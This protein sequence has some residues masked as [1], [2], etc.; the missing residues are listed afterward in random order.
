[1]DPSDRISITFGSTTTELSVIFDVHPL[2]KIEFIAS[3]KIGARWTSQGFPAKFHDEF[4]TDPFFD[5]VSPLTNQGYEL[6]ICGQS[7][8]G[9]QST[10]PAQEIVNNSHFP[11]KDGCNLRD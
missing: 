8:D 6:F 2:V 7:N 5:M 4:R 9:D 11:D 10:M 1:M 3:D